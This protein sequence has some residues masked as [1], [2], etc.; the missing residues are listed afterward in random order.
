MDTISDKS[1]HTLSYFKHKSL[2]EKDV[3]Y[4]SVLIHSVKRQNWHCVMLCCVT[5]IGVCMATMGW[6]MDVKA[7]MAD[8]R[9]SSLTSTL[10]WTSV[11]VRG[12]GGTVM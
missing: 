10:P 7:E 8:M 11:C 5:C 9:T 4:C 3:L 1:S 6:S 12:E 2:S